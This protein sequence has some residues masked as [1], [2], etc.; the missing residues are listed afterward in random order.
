MSRL[1]TLGVPPSVTRLQFLDCAA[2]LIPPRA[3][4]PVSLSLFDSYARGQHLFHVALQK[5]DPGAANFV[6]RNST[7]VSFI[8]LPQGLL[9][10][11]TA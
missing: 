5:I 11:Y 10:D 6:Q 2:F 8:E 4:I 1:L 7:G 9:V 3:G